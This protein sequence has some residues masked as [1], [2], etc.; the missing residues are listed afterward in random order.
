MAALVLGL[1]ACGLAGIPL[2]APKEP[3]R[4]DATVTIKRKYVVVQ[5]DLGL[6]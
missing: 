4:I 3:I 1:G 6:Q 2:E 5:S